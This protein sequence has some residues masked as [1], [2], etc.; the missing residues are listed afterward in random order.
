M[1]EAGEKWDSLVFLF[2]GALECVLPKEDNCSETQC[3]TAEGVVSCSPA[4]AELQQQQDTGSV[5]PRIKNDYPLLG[6]AAISKV[7]AKRRHTF[8]IP[9]LP[10]W[11]QSC[12]CSRCQRSNLTRSFSM[13]LGGLL[14]DAGQS[15]AIVRQ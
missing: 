7:V 5:K 1:V 2:P 3:K 6:F 14:R 13:W 15:P 12:C 10:R 4:A 11:N 8:T 9:R